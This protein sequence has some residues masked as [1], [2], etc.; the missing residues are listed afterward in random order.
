LDFS[1]QAT[2]EI[3]CPFGAEISQ[4]IPNQTN[5]K[6]WNI[7]SFFNEHKFTESHE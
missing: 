6:D 1:P 7:T 3:E 2:E 4:I 5:K